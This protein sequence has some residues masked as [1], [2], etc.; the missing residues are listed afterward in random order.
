MKKRVEKKIDL[1]VRLGDQ[2]ALICPLC[3]ESILHHYDVFLFSKK[4]GSSKEDECMTIVVGK[5]RPRW[6]GDP[7]AIVS[8]IAIPKNPSFDRSGLV[9]WMWCEL[10]E[11]IPLALNILQHKG[12]TYMAWDDSVATHPRWKPAP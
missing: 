12:T 9:L 2:G 4:A 8:Q 11:A 3:D 6:D 1:T 7:P 5:D 10:C